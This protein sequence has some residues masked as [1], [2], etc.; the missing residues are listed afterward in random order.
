MRLRTV[1]D[2]VQERFA[3]PLALDRLVALI[4][5]AMAEARQPGE[6]KAFTR[7]MQELQPYAATPTGV[8]LDVPHWLRRL[9]QE[10]DEGVQAELLRAIGRLGAREAL[11]VLARFADPGGAQQRR[12]PLVR[13]AAIEAIAHLGVPEAR[14]LLELYSRDKEPAV[15]KAAELALR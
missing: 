11:K 4:E 8:G 6:R 15:R 9:E 12:S 2:H 14:G 7:L 5:P 3:K 1:A 13:A 10:E